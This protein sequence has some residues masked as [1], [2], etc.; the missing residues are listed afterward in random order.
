MQKKTIS[1]RTFIVPLVFVAAIVCLCYLIS[2]DP[3]SAKADPDIIEMYLGQSKT[4][5]AKKK[6]SKTSHD[7]SLATVSSN[8]TSLNIYPIK[9]GTDTIAV[10][11][12]DGS[13]KKYTVK[14]SES[15][16]KGE[17]ISIANNSYGN[18]TLALKFTNDS[19]KTFENVTVAY[20]AY[21]RKTSP[22]AKEKEDKTDIRQI[23][24]GT[25]EYYVIRPH[26]TRYLTVVLDKKL[27]K[28]EVLDKKKCT[29]TLDS[30]VKEDY[31][32]DKHN[33]FYASHD[34][35]SLR[36]ALEKDERIKLTVDT[37]MPDTL[38]CINRMSSL[39]HTNQLRIHERCKETIKQ[40]QGYEWD[41]KASQRGE[42][43]PV[44]K[45]DHLVDSMRGPIM[46][47]LLGKR[48]VAGIIHL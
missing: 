17:F 14:I 46:H 23:G 20:S 18:A 42:D 25:E 22:T 1:K 47:D 16:I 12:A 28:G 21:V 15:P 40:V 31:N 2:K 30:I 48:I 36:T 29:F 38:D 44:K 6:I 39:F 10:D 27:E 9:T 7:S 11:F 34:A 26:E 41:S 45:D 8:D 33:I 19:D 37:F 13:S 3:V 35:E 43:K 4:I 24:E 5:N 32:L